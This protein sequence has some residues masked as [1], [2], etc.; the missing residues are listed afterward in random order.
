M[1]KLTKEELS[2]LNALGISEDETLDVSRYPSKAERKKVANETGAKVTYG[3]TPHFKCGYCL[4][5][6][7]GN[8]IVCDPKYLA[9]A[10]R[11][12]A[13]GTLY[14]AYSREK[15]YIKVGSS[16]KITDRS[17]SIRHQTYGGFSDW[18]I[19]FSTTVQESAGEIEIEMQQSIKEFLVNAEY[20]KDGKKQRTKEMFNY[21]V[22]KAIRKFKQII[23][24]HSK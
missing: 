22:E 6:P 12:K 23:E 9:Y 15:G 11:H 14:I 5:T 13:G 19:S 10:Q 17:K 20:L 21:P 8:C 1:A 3:Y 7:S 18:V 24:K 4:K 2:I 16:T